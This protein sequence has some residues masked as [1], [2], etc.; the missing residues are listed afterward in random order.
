MCIR[1]RLYNAGLV[2][3]FDTNVTQT[4]VSAYGYVFQ[5]Q[6]QTLDQIFVTPSLFAELVQVRIAHINADFAA[7]YDA[8]VAR[9][10]SDH[11]PQTARFCRDVTAPVIN[12][13]LSQTMLWPPNHD[14]RRV[15][16]GVSVSDDSGEALPFTLVAVTSSEPDNGEDDGDTTG[17]VVVV[18]ATTFDLRAERS[19]TGNGRVYYVEYT[20]TDSCGNVGTGAATVTVPKSMGK[21]AKGVGSAALDDTTDT[22]LLPMI[23]N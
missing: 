16:A 20:A 15:T 3:L 9:G 6:T 7:D 23:S 18:D 11:D 21:N 8:D 1:D 17:D 5:G 19:G 10:T 22:M 12:V 4:P 13:T 14:L 2:N